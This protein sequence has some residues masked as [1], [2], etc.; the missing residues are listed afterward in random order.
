M[1]SDSRAQRL[2]DEFEGAGAGAIRS[3]LN[4]F[5]YFSWWSHS[6]RQNPPRPGGIAQ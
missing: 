6:V 1:T 4:L 5:P 3:N 2:V